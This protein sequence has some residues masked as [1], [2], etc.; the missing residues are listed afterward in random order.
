MMSSLTEYLDAREAEIKKIRSE[1]L[2]EQ[3]QIK[4]ARAAIEDKDAPKIESGESNSPN[5]KVE[6]QTLTIKEMVL[7]VLRD[8]L[9]GGPA[10][11]SEIINAVNSEFGKDFPRT[12]VSPQLSRLRQS[13][14]LV[15]YDGKW[16]IP[17]SQKVVSGAVVT[18]IRDT[19][20]SGAVKSETGNADDISGFYNSHPAERG[21]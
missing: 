15:D 7:H 5:N 14:D 17:E 10:T 20:P 13:G 18:S 6:R 4:A 12:S 9:S 11:A 2:K 16:A 3:K 21:A 19:T 8:T 1:L